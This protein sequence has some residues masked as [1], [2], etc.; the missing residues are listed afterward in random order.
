MRDSNR[1][2]TKKNSSSWQKES[3][4]IRSSV[5]FAEIVVDSAT[6]KRFS[7]LVEVQ[8]HR[9]RS[10]FSFNSFFNLEKSVFEKQCVRSH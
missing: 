10:V 4:R 7:V 9:K 5:C 2:R 3:D 6:K 8:G 1:E